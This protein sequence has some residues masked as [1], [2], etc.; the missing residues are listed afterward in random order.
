MLAK[1][2]ISTATNRDC[3]SS[4]STSRGRGPLLLGDYPQT[5]VGWPCPQRVPQTRLGVAVRAAATKGVAEMTHAARPTPRE[6]LSEVGDVLH[7]L[8]VLLSAPLYRR[9]HLRWGATANETT[10]S[11]PGDSLMRTA[12]FRSTRA[13]TIDAPPHA[14]WPWLVQVGCLRAG[15]YSNDLLDNLGRPSA[16]TILL[17]FQNLELGQWIPMSPAAPS[18]RT[19]LKVHSFVL[20]EWLLWTK[21]DSTWVWRLTPTGNGGT[22]LVTR[23]H[24]AYDWSH[25]ATAFLGLL[26]M[27]FGDFAMLRRMLRG[28]KQRAESIAPVTSRTGSGHRSSEQQ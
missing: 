22:R 11:L 9:W 16:T 19:A 1:L 8:P 15:F 7:D 26:L 21:R 3:A 10:E 27:E 23:I 25:L 28:I 17:D 18:E 5:E 6:L 12:Q 24:V 20:E 4:P 14:V 13:I 2:T